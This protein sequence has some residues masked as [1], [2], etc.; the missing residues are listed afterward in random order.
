MHGGEPPLTG[1]FPI[2]DVF[3]SGYHSTLLS[4][5]SR[6]AGNG[7]TFAGHTERSTRPRVG[8]TFANPVTSTYVSLSG[9]AEVIEDTMRMMDLWNTGTGASVVNG[10]RII[11]TLHMV[12]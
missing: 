10:D 1:V 4:I 12:Q 5:P 11:R 7:D 2:P 8:V 6:R 9:S 3:M